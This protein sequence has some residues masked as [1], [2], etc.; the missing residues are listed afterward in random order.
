MIKEQAQRLWSLAL[1][2]KKVSAGVI[3]VIIL[4][5]IIS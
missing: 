5:I 2:H 3:A 4:L 1:A